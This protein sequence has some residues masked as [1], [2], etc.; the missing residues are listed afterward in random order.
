MYVYKNLSFNN[1]LYS[2]QPWLNF[3]YIKNTVLKKQT[4][5]DVITYDYKN[6]SYQ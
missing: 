6:E 1:I 3:V 2:V 4:G 5:S